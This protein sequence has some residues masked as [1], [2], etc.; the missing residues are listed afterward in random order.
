MIKQNA[1]L[2]SSEARLEPLGVQIRIQ[3][4]RTHVESK[5]G[6]CQVTAT[7]TLAVSD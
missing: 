1:S 6:I 7:A 2:A 5:R 3:D 4:I